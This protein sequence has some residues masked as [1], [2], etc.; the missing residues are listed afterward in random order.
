[1][2]FVPS[3]EKV[4]AFR[5]K[6]INDA[7]YRHQF[8][9]NPLAALRAVGINVPDGTQ[10][11][12]VSRAD[13]EAV[14]TQLKATFGPRLDEIVKTGGKNLSP[15]E[16]ATLDLLSFQRALEPEDVTGHLQTLQQAQPGAQLPRLAPGQTPAG[17]A[18][19]RRA[20]LY[21]LSVAGTVD[22]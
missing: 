4:A 15:S 21:K 18:A 12:A 5:S 2:P 6:L 22:W 14:V 8:A 20:T 3:A 17:L 19:A 10:L 13:L 11:P 1:M 7:A 16:M 9:D